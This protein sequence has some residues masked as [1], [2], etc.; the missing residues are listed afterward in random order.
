MFQLNGDEERIFIYCVFS[1]QGESSHIALLLPLSVD[2]KPRR[3]AIL[4]KTRPLFEPGSLG[5]ETSLRK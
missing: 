1:S 5:F 2:G 3:R 4:G